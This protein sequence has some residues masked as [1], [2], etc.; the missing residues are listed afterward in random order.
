[1]PGFVLPAREPYG[2]TLDER[3]TLPLPKGT[4]STNL[5]VSSPSQWS[6][7]LGRSDVLLEELVLS[8]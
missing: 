1:M 3:Y 8:Q 5:L 4:G 6:N 7:L 2:D